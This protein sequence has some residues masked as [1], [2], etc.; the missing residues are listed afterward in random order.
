VRWNGCGTV[1]VT[2]TPTD[3][4]GTVEIPYVLENEEGVRVAGSLPIT[5][6][7]LDSQGRVVIQ[8]QQIALQGQRLIE[9]AGVPASDQ[10]QNADN[11]PFEGGGASNDGANAGMTMLL[12][13]TPNGEDADDGNDETGDRSSPFDLAW[14]LSLVAAAGLVVRRNR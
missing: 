12:D 1:F 6:A 9:V 3:F 8:Q 7:D 2:V 4:S 13:S 5:S 10:L 11:C 14:L